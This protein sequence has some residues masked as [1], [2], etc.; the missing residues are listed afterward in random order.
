[1]FPPFTLRYSRLPERFFAP[2][3][4]VPVASPRLVAFNRPLAEELGFALPALG[5][6]VW[7]RRVTMTLHRQRWRQSEDYFLVETP[8]FTPAIQDAP[9]AATIRE[10]RWWSLAEMRHTSQR[11]APAGLARI[12]LDY[13]ESGPPS[14]PPEI[15]IIED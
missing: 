7:R 15:E 2:F 5:P 8:G 13:R 12:V 3:D 11:L 1:M 14:S 10:F 6:L 9:E 4:P